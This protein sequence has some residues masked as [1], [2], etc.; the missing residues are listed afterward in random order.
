MISKFKLFESKEEYKVLANNYSS[1]HWEYDNIDVT[2]QIL[3]DDSGNL[4]LEINKMHV[5]TGIGAG[6]FP[7]HLEFKKIGTLQ[8][9]DLGTVRNLLSKYS[10]DQKKF[11]RFWEDEEGNRMSLSE[12]LKMYKTEQKPQL[13][14]I[15]PISN[16][17][18]KEKIEDIELIQYSDRSYALFGEGTKKIKDQLKSLGCR[19]NPFLTD[20][21]TGQKRAGWIFSITKLDKIK[22]LIS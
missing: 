13:K 4:F 19:F 20:P 7:Q 6:K 16:F 3:L 18:D 10:Y 15:E 17:K 11:S 22:E 5:K 1:Y 8:K 12:I 14:Y 2:A 21:K 9:P